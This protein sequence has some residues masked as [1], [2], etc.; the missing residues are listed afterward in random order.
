MFFKSYPHN[1]FL[2]NSSHALIGLGSFNGS[3]TLR[4]IETMF[5]QPRFAENIGDSFSSGE[6][7][8][9]SIP[10]L[11]RGLLILDLLQPA[12]SNQTFLVNGQPVDVV[13]G[14]TQLFVP[15]NRTQSFS[16]S[17]HVDLH[18]GSRCGTSSF[19][20]SFACQPKL[21]VLSFLGDF[22][23]DHL[24]NEM[25]LSLAMSKWGNCSGCDEDLDAD[26]QIGLLDV[27]ATIDFWKN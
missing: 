25:D 9:S 4:R 26:G 16:V 15:T 20:G 1:F 2:K 11:N 6:F 24:V 10:N 12:I 27:V 3:C 21:L 14:S 17:G 8:F 23:H 13:A 7:S 22:N 5:V 19:A 18:S